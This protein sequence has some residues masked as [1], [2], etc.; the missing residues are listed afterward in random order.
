MR[1]RR[2][3]LRCDW[4]LGAITRRARFS[5]PSGLAPS[6]REARGRTSSAVAQALYQSAPWARRCA[7]LRA[8]AMFLDESSRDGMVLWYQ[9]QRA[10]RLEARSLARARVGRRPE[11]ADPRHLRWTHTGQ[12]GTTADAV[13]WAERQVVDNGSKKGVQKESG[14]IASQ[15]GR[16]SDAD[17]LCI[18]AG[19]IDGWMDGKLLSSP[20][21]G[22]A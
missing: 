13:S 16:R 18:D 6:A 2:A 20:A 5:K 22:S 19:L 15:G 12:R 7:G 1:R 21:G 10:S 14:W 8:A 4:D 9:P 11:E 3:R 17:G